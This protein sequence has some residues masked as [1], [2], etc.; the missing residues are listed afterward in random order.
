MSATARSC[1]APQDSGTGGLGLTVCT[2]S[3]GHPTG[4]CTVTPA[5]VV[6]DTRPVSLWEP[7]AR[8]QVEVTVI[9]T[10]TVTSNGGEGCRG[11]GPRTP[12]LQEGQRRARGLGQGREAR[13]GAWRPEAGRS[14]GGARVWGGGCMD[15]VLLLL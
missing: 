14:R 13:G 4:V 15:K 9:V 3:F 12:G 5:A 8:E 10:Q 1:R 11:L 6:S 7:T 2:H